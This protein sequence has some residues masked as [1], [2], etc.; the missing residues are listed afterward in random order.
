MNIEPFKEKQNSQY[1]GVI[2]DTSDA[3]SSF[4]YLDLRTLHFDQDAKGKNDAITLF[5]QTEVVTIIGEN[6]AA[7]YEAIEDHSIS[8]VCKGAS[9]D[10]NN[11]SIKLVSITK[12]AED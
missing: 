10:P 4:S 6:L 5:F 3:I 1:L 7:L 11:P 12:K 2:A 8:R 9:K